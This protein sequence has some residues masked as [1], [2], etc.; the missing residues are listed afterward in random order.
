MYE[1]YIK[2]KTKIKIKCK[3]YKN[4]NLLQFLR[5]K[6]VSTHRRCL[7][8]LFME[9]KNNMPTLETAVFTRM[10]DFRETTDIFYKNLT[11]SLAAINRVSG[12]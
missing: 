4:N 8:Y 7:A 5:Y 3:Y 9:D 12:P 2:M 11:S 1:M 6:K 10:D